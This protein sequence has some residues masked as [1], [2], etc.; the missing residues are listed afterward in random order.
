MRDQLFDR[1][2]TSSDGRHDQIEVG[3]ECVTAAHQCHF[4]LVE[5]RVGKHDVILDDA[6]E[7]VST[8][9]CDVSKAGLNCVS[10]S[11]R[12]D[13]R[14]EAVAIGRLRDGAG[15]LVIRQK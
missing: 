4:A 11:C 13:C 3:L 9:V 1:Y 12:I 6:H 2:Q 8:A 15:R 5:L 10:A 7:N 14:I